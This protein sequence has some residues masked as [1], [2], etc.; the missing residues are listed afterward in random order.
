MS[1]LRRLQQQRRLPE[2]G[3]FRRSLLRSGLQ[4]E[5]REPLQGRAGLHDRRRLRTLRVCQSAVLHPE[6][7]RW[8]VRRQ[9][10]RQ[11]SG[12]GRL[13]RQRRLPK[14]GLFGRALLRPS[15]QWEL[16]EPLQGHAGVHERQRLRTLGLR[17]SAVLHSERCRWPVRRQLWREM[18]GPPRLQQQRRLPEW[19]V[20]SGHLWRQADGFVSWQST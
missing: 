4:W 14:R 15:L 13:Q 11:V 18:S 1:R 8:P 3:V 7:C 5:L 9:L 2:R 12:L 6:R 16:R 20:Q 17:Q 10:R 19:G